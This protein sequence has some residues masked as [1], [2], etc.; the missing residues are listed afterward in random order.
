MGENFNFNFSNKWKQIIWV[1]YKTK[2]IIYKETLKLIKHTF[3]YYK[4]YIVFIKKKKKKNPLQSDFIIGVVVFG[5][6]VLKN[7]FNSNSYS[8]TLSP[9]FAV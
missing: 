2:V 4:F 6:H 1:G 7:N 5:F 3:I 8:Y 9:H